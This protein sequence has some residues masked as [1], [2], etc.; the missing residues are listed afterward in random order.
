MPPVVFQQLVLH[1]LHQ[2]LLAP[3]GQL[4]QVKQPP[5]RPPGL[6]LAGPRVLHHL[7]DSALGLNSKEYFSLSF[8]FGPPRMIL[9][10]VSVPRLLRREQPPLHAPAPLWQASKLATTWCSFSTTQ[11]LHA[12]LC[13][14]IPF[15]HQ[16]E[17]LPKPWSP[18]PSTELFN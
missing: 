5:L 17:A 6:F 2:R 7:Q 12:R 3:G 10:A 13:S 14:K 16:N 8:S 4:P 11:S 18:P 9:D 15:E 1:V